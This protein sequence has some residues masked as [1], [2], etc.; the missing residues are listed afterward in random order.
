MGQCQLESNPLQE[1][2]SHGSHLGG[3]LLL[4]LLVLFTLSVDP[5]SERTKLLGYVAVLVIAL[6]FFELVEFVIPSTE[7]GTG[8]DSWGGGGTGAGA[9]A[10]TEGE[11][12]KADHAAGRFY[13]Q[14]KVR[15]GQFP[16][17]SGN[18]GAED[19]RCL[20]GIIDRCRLA[21]M[22]NKSGGIV[23][24]AHSEVSTDNLKALVGNADVIFACAGSPG[25]LKTSWVK[26]GAEIISI[27]TTFDEQKD[28]LVSD[29]DNGDLDDIANRYSPVPGGVG[30]LSNGFLFKNVA[31]AAWKRAETTGDVD[32]TWNR[33][34]GTIERTFHFRNYDFAL[35]FSDDVNSMSRELDHH[36]NMTFRHKCVDGVD[37]TLEFF[38]YEA[39][40][41]TGKDY[42]AAKMVNEIAR[43]NTK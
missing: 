6:V 19:C 26:P 37:V 39:N 13:L 40:E 32:D 27:G 4:L 1:F 12:A 31:A 25:L 43:K 16:V 38:T 42:T 34:S 41:V 35:S 23:T 9:G 21:Y 3:L 24:V 7:T 28:L 20:L 2:D 8:R 33:T 29:F 17:A 10:G 22:A 14:I 5:S 18:D 36:A 30:P 15:G 11:Q